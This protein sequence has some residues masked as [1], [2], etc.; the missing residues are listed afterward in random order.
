MLGGYDQPFGSEGSLRKVKGTLHW[1]SALA[2]QECEV[3]LY[4]PILMD[5]ES[6]EEDIETEE[7]AESEAAPAKDFISA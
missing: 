1:V 6:I 4:E 2:A 7:G 3:R 5:E